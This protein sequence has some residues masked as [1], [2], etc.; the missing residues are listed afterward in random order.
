VRGIVALVFDGLDGGGDIGLIHQGGDVGFQ[1][2]VAGHVFIEGAHE[3]G[4]VIIGERGG[5]G[6]EDVDD[7][8]R[9]V[10]E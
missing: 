5:H 8:A 1:F 3:F 2:G 6:A 10:G 9:G 4:K 7:F